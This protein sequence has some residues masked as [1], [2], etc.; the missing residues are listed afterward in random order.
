MDSGF[1]G[2]NNNTDR[3]LMKGVYLDTK[4]AREFYDKYNKQKLAQ[5]YYDSQGNDKKYNVDQLTRKKK[6]ELINFLIKMS[7]KHLYTISQ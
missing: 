1:D 3:D 2:S 7:P 4:V 5:A 6:P